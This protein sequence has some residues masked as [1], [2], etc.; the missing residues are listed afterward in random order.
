MFGISLLLAGSL[1]VDAQPSRFAQKDGDPTPGSKPSSF[2]KTARDRHEYDLLD[3]RWD[4]TVD[5]SQESIS[6]VA[7]N[8]VKTLLKNAQLYFDAARLNISSVRVNGETVSYKVVGDVLEVLPHLTTK[9]DPKTKKTSTTV[10][11]RAAG[12][13]LKVEI[14]YSTRP[15]AGVYFVPEANAYPAQTAVVFT[16]GEMEDTRYWLPTYDSPNDKATSEGIIRV[17]SNWSVLSNGALIAKK[18]EGKQAVWHWKIS[19]PHATYLISFVG[20]EYTALKDGVWEGIEVTNW[21]PKGVEPW[22]DNAFGGTHRIVEFF[23]GLVGVK[24]PWEKYAQSAV[25]EFM[26]GGMENVSCTTNTITSTFPKEVNPLQSATGL[27]A[28]ELAHQ[29]FGDLITTSDWSHIWVNEGW[30]SF[31]PT[32]WTRKEQG[33]DEF[34]LERVGTYDGGL[35]GMDGANRPMVFKGYGD[36]MEMFDGNAYPGGATRMFMLMNTLGEEAFWKATKEYL[37]EWGYKNT[38]TEIFFKAFEKSSGKSLDSFRKQWF[39]TAGYPKFQ[40]TRSNKKLTI[41]QKTEGFSGEVSVKIVGADGGSRLEKV[42]YGPNSSQTLDIADGE[43]FFVDP[44]SW[45]MCRV[46]YPTVTAEERLRLWK[47][48]D[49]AGD[50]QRVLGIP[51]QPFGDK[52]A[53]ELLASEST[54]GLSMGLIDQIDN[55]DTLMAMVDGSTDLRLVNHILGKFGR[56]KNEDRVLAKLKQVFES[57]PNDALKR[58]AFNSLLA[59]T[60]DEKLAQQGWKTPTYDMGIRTDALS[61]IT[62]K[63]PKAARALAWEAIRGKAP[64]PV[65][66]AAMIQLAMLKDEKGDRSVYEMLEQGAR[67]RSYGILSTAITG[68]AIYGDPAAV[69]VLRPLKNHSLHFIRNQVKG[70]LSAFGE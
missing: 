25:P 54:I 24:Y 36:P 62:R 6:G 22:V 12:E 58:T 23:S 30:A 67:N 7:T 55:L 13:T 32:F 21:A 47:A 66:K 33:D 10:K 34:H 1:L 19:K 45:L 53:T 63:N 16:Q 40:V 38:D 44:G 20:G 50:R 31:L 68:L 9:I 4:V 8:T 65:R 18:Q 46:Q 61:W 26:F 60:N 52:V 27:V 29:W 2:P 41:A 11:N 43:T 56:Y 15:D 42:A 48:A 3:I 37:Q 70:V 51:G 39:Y 57:H 64:A 35:G 5:P 14:R 69:K 17:P 49:N 59:L 28:H